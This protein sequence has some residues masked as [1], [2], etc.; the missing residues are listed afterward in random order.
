MHEV[1]LE[2]VVLI[3][4][5]SLVSLCTVSRFRLVS[6]LVVKLLVSKAR[7]HNAAISK[8]PAY[9]IEPNMGYGT[10]GILYLGNSCLCHLAA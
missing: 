7:M 2:L 10:R 6:I 3:S 9:V 4:R 1:D 8:C 5:S